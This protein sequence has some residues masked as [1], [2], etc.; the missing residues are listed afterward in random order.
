MA[1]SRARL[2]S[3]AIVLSLFAAACGSG[4][5]DNLASVDPGD[6]DTVAGLVDDSDIGVDSDPEAEGDTPEPEVEPLCTV[7]DEETFAIELA[8]DGTERAD[9]QL[10]AVFY[11]ADGSEIANGETI[12]S[13]RSLRPGEL[14]VNEGW[15]RFDGIGGTCE[16]VQTRRGASSDDG[17]EP[18]D[19][20]T[21]NGRDESGYLDFDVSVIAIEDGQ[22]WSTVAFLDADGARR[23]THQGWTEE[24]VIGE[25]VAVGDTDISAEDAEG[26]VDC[27]VVGRINF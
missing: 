1:P 10:T 15:S 20:C 17:P 24:A 2:I 27:E 22:V 6:E 13:I 14:T 8:N 21:I 23:A 25:M 9:Y 18:E 5:V 7:I 16:V 26:V 11:L 12:V 19:T 4:P 3:L